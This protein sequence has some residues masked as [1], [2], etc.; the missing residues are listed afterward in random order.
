MRSFLQLTLDLFTE[1]ALPSKKEVNREIAG[2]ESAQNATELIASAELIASIPLVPSEPLTS[3]LRPTHFAHPRANREARL[4]AR[5]GKRIGQGG[6]ECIVA[7]ELRRA[8]RKT[9]GFMVGVDGLVVSAPRWVPLYEVDKALQEKSAWIV[10][11]L[12]EAQERQQKQAQSQI[13]WKEGAVIPFL[14]ESVI[15]VID[16]RQ[17][18]GSSTAAQGMAQLQSDASALAGVPRLTLHVGL[19]HD[20]APERIRDSVQAWLMR[21]AKRVFE[22]R[23][24]HFAPQLNVRWTKLSLSN[25]SSRW[26]SAGSDGAIRLNWRLIHFRQNV[27]DYVVVHELSH[28]RVMDHSPRFWSTVE[29]IMPDYAQRKGMLKDE[30]IPKW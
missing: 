2:K 27:I 14:G 11:K 8:K 25:A 9:I 1:V 22:E 6:G 23:L 18:T 30:A 10:N 5:A 28:L 29:S 21:Q 3:V 15:I 20:A 19:P 16:P 17:A 12:A 24:N 26:G 13:E 4:Q 7:Y